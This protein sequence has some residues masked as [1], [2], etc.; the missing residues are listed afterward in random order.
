LDFR[1][2]G[3]FDFAQDRQTEIETETEKRRPKIDDRGS[4]IEKR[5]HE[6]RD[7]DGE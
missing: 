4:R 1:F 3:S 7:R 5:R 6:D 2:G